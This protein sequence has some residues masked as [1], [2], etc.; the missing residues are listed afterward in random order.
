MNMQRVTPYAPTLP[1]AGLV[2]AVA[3]TVL[4]GWAKQEETLEQRKGPQI[5][6]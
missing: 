3:F 2:F 6:R 4:Y 1:F 5:K